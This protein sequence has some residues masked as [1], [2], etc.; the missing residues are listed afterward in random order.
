MW[1]SRFTKRASNWNK[2]RIKNSN[3]YGKLHFFMEIGIW[4]QDLRFLKKVVLSDVMS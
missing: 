1:I 3:E 2:T 4:M